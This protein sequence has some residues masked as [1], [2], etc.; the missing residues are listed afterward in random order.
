MHMGR[1]YRTRLEV[2]HDLLEASQKT[3]RKTRIIGLANLNPAY[4]EIYA[5]FCLDHHLLQ[6]TTDGYRPTDR[7]EPVLAAI[8]R[9]ISKSS[10][11]D[12]ALRSLASVVRQDPEVGDLGGPA[13][14]VYGSD[15]WEEG[16]WHSVPRLSLPRS[17]A[18]ARPPV[19]GPGSDRPTFF[20][21]SRTSA[22][23]PMS[24]GMSPIPLDRNRSIE[25]SSRMRFPPEVVP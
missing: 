8:R 16:L 17:G 24:L 3:S 25:K 22:P 7:T 23:T 19:A 15:G 6:F 14:R 20:L 5:R 21:N 12:D 1:K 4:F 9:V 18:I 2:L 11:L 13:T 10:E